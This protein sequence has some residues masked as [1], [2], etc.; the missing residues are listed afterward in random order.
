MTPSCCHCR[1][2]TSRGSRRCTRQRRNAPAL[3]ACPVRPNLSCVDH[4]SAAAESSQGARSG[5]PSAT[6]STRRSHRLPLAARRCEVSGCATSEQSCAPR[7]PTRRPES[8]V[9]SARDHQSSQPESVRSQLPA[10]RGQSA[11][12]TACHPRAAAAQATWHRTVLDS[13]PPSSC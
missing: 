9:R 8:R 4:R 10:R 12:S 7:T 1:P 5:L 11:S 2:M 6:L 13:Q 3:Q